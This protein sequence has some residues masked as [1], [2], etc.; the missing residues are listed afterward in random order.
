MSRYMEQPG[1]VLELQQWE[2][3]KRERN[4]APPDGFVGGHGYPDPEI[5]AWVD[6]LN[7][8]PRLCTLQ[9]CAGHRC[10]RGLCC[11]HCAASGAGAVGEWPEDTHVMSGQSVAVA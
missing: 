4:D 2:R 3:A 7:R 1:K 8:L 11:V 9:S 10:V 6:R 5:Y